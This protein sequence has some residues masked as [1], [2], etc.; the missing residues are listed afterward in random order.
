LERASAIALS[1]FSIHLLGDVISPPLIG[2]LSD[3]S[4]L[5]QAVKIVPLAVVLAAV[6]WTFAAMSKPRLNR[7]QDG[8]GSA[9][10]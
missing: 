2:A 3:A 4:S 1:V 9:S 10:A 8:R 5:Q 6:G 7:R